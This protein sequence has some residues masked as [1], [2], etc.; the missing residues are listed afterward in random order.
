MRRFGLFVSLC[1]AIGTS[2]ACGSTAAWQ[3]YYSAACDAR[4]SMPGEPELGRE[5]TPSEAGELTLSV[6]R[7][8]DEGQTFAYSCRSF[9]MGYFASRGA[10]RIADEVLAHE[11]SGFEATWTRGEPRSTD[12]MTRA[13]TLTHGKETAE[14]RVLALEV[15]AQTH[16]TMT[17]GVSVEVA[18]RFVEGIEIHPKPTTT[19]ER[20]R[21]AECLASIVMPGAPSSAV[22]GALFDHATRDAKGHSYVLRCIYM[23]DATAKLTPAEIFHRSMTDTEADGTWKA[24]DH[25]DV[26]VQGRHGRRQRYVSASGQE[27]L[28]VQ[29]VVDGPRLQLASVTLPAA[30]EA[31]V[32]PYF[33]AYRLHGPR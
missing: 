10:G 24:R 11:M 19:P 32:A 6:F 18:R 2:A 4:I 26:E 12:A 20:V 31:L 13:A 9:P 33:K 15:G 3:T 28:V 30:D 22:E 17:I 29:V 7:V 1:G 21:S 25:E 5:I 8:Q 16:A 27:L 14:L 23:D